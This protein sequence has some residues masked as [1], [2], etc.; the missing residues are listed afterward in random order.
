MAR[1]FA[2]A[3]KFW[4]LLDYGTY[5]YMLIKAQ[6]HVKLGSYKTI[7]TFRVGKVLKNVF[8]STITRYPELVIIDHKIHT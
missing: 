7:Y 4:A 8:L 5:L 6:F 1:T 3:P 2:T